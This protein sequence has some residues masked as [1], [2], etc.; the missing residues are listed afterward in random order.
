MALTMGRNGWGGNSKPP[1]LNPELT[2]Q[3]QSW[4]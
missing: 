4:S 2:K 1:G 3:Q